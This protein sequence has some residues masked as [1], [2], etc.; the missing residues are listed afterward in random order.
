LLRATDRL[1]ELTQRNLQTRQQLDTLSQ[2]AQALEEQISVLRGSLLLSKILYQ[3]HQALP[4]LTLDGD[5]ADEIADIRR[6]QFEL[7]QQRDTLSNPQ[8]YVESLL[9]KQ[10]PEQVTP[11]LRDTLLALATTRSEL[12][13]RLGREL[14]S[15]LN[16]SITLQLN[17]KQLHDTSQA[18]RATLEEQM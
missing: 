14:N 18:L 2:A 8:A 6:Y 17:Q 16:E 9:S 15:L 1:N 11:E 5:L 7:S 3:Q 4:R 13:D 12:F 10:P